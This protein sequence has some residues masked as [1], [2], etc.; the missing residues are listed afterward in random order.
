MEL[1]GPTADKDESTGK[2]AS[3]EQIRRALVALTSDEKEKLSLIAR[4]WLRRYQLDRAKFLPSD[5][6]NEVILRTL[7]GRRKWPY[8]SVNFMYYLD[9]TMGSIARHEYDQMKR[10]T[11]IDPNFSDPA[12]KADFTDLDEPY[13]ELA[14]LNAAFSDDPVILQYLLLKYEG[15]TVAQVAKSMGKNTREIEAIKKRANRRVGE[16]SGGVGKHGEQEA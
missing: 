15:K 14:V 12:P 9:R 16:L 10:F 4:S 7:D 8:K 11:S 13:P 1:A 5:L 3:I 6:V 2:V